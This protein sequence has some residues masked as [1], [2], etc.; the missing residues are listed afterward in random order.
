MSN[1]GWRSGVAHAKQ[2][3]LYNSINNIGA[4]LITHAGVPVDGVE[5]T[6][7]GEV[8]KGTLCLDHTNGNAYINA[9]TMAS[10]VWKLVTRAA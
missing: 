8:A 3:K 10:P 2:I 1:F 6:G 5:G 7:V 4:S 9:G